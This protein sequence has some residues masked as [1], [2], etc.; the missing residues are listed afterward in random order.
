MVWDLHATLR[1]LRKTSRRAYRAGVTQIASRMTPEV[2][3]EP[4]NSLVSRERA[5]GFFPTRQFI[6]KS[7]ARFQAS[8]AVGKGVHSIWDRGLPLEFC[9]TAAEAETLLVIFHGALGLDA[10]LP[11]FAGANIARH[12]DVARLSF[13]DPSLY[14]TPDLVLAWYAG[15]YAQPDLQN[16]I[17]RVIQ[18]TAK[19]I[20]AKRIILF[21]ASGGGYASLIQATK[22][23]DTTVVIANAQ[24][25]VL[26][27]RRNH[28]DNYI[29]LAWDGDRKPF[30]EQ[31]LYSAVVALREND[32]FPKLYYMQNSTDRFHIFGHLKP[33]ADEFDKYP[34]FQLLFGDWGK[35]HVAPP[36]ALLQNVLQQVVSFDEAGLS[37]TGFRQASVYKDL[38]KDL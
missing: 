20:G 23:P 34:Q 32:S 8:E 5:I 26:K 21:G 12:L 22:I 24:T 38:Y 25:D 27:Y 35:G 13:T 14:L 6:W 28:V 11:I 30:I 33:L 4:N 18:S 17:S 10:H 29:D 16:Q 15:S 9:L 7:F 3:W 2:L 1:E 19:S 31:S 36:K 37:E